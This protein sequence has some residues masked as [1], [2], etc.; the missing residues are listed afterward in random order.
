MIADI[1]DDFE[2]LPV[3][4]PPM[5]SSLVGHNGMTRFFALYYF[6]KATWSDGWNSATFS[7]Y[8]AFEPLVNHPTI[9]FDLFGKDLGSDDGPPQHALLCDRQDRLM[10]VGGYEEVMRFLRQHTP[11][12]A[13][14]FSADELELMRRHM[15]NLTTE[16][17]REQGMF[18]FVFGPTPA[19]RELGGEM[20]A[21]LDQFVTAETLDRYS[22]AADAGNLYAAYFVMQFVQ[23]VKNRRQG[24]E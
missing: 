18:E 22:K 7:Y 2:R 9:A 5:L 20:V 17:M 21:W 23:R 13:T 14:P 12:R 8:A 15:E 3:P 6:S 19:Q 4:L 1:P 24:G 10:Y 16:E 11:R